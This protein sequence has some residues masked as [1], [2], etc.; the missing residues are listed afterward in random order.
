MVSG[1]SEIPIARHGEAEPEVTS[2]GAAQ[3]RGETDHAPFPEVEGLEKNS[4]HYF[5]RIA[6]RFENFYLGLFP[7]HVRISNVRGRRI[8]LVL[9]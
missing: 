3:K 1:R 9:N 2:P 4:L 5:E 8:K 7:V 6:E